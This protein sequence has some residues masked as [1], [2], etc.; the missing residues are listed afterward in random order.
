[1][2][3]ET[4]IGEALRPGNPPPIGLPGAFAKS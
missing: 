1:L 2:A 3:W 4:A